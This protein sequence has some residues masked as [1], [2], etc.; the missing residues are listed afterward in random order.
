MDLHVGLIGV[1]GALTVFFGILVKIVGIPEQ[2][3]QNGFSLLTPQ[4]VEAS[5]V[6]HSIT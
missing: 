4:A 2:I 5:V 3:H 6:L 1:V